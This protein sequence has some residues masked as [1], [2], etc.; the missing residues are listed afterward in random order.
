M[1]IA[2]RKPTRSPGNQSNTPSQPDAPQ[3]QIVLLIVTGMSPAVL[4]ETIWGLAQKE[5]IVPNR[6]VVV[7]TR[8]GRTLLEQELLT[9]PSRNEPNIWQALRG[10]ILPSFQN[11][12]R[13]NLEPIREIT[14]TN[15]RKGQSD[16]VEDFR[17]SSANDAMADFV[18]EQVRNLVE[19]PDVELIASIAGG[20]K[21][22]GA[23]LYAC[24]S[25]LGREKDRLT[26][27]LVNAPFDDSRLSPRF[28]FPKQAKQKLHL[29]SKTVLAKNA[30]IDLI[31]IPFVPLRKL[32]ERDFIRK[33]SSFTELVNRYRGEAGKAA[34]RNLKLMLRRSRR[35]IEVNG[36]RVQTSQ[37]QQ[38]L[39]LFLA[40]PSMTAVRNQIRKYAQAI[41]PLRAYAEQLRAE[42]RSEDGFD[43]RDDAQVPSSFDDESLRKLLN[44]L[45]D[46]LDEAGSGP[47]AL[48]SCLPSRGRFS[49]DLAPTAIV[50]RD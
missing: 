1:K 3:S 39:L 40:D 22:L 31:D 12:P 50:I 44:E 14:M 35:E 47:E 10:H 8:R 11:D 33:P 32:F 9:A 25:L 46:K 2:K 13:L 34:S 7:T 5:R 23:L 18:L 20:R 26:H 36:V 28:Y 6:V 43:W 29:G 4:T 45:R 37:L 42:C 49:L 15:P 30:Q 38:V 16:P 17:T 24:I 48:I 21:T 41:E 19:T 27:V